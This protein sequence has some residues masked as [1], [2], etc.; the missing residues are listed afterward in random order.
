MRS[1]GAVRARRSPEARAWRKWYKTAA[2]QRLRGAQLAK[3]PLCQCPHCQEGKQRTT[4]ATVVDHKIPH[5]G[6]RRLFFDSKNLRSMSKP[7][8]D[9]FKQ[10]Q[11]RGGAGFFKGVD[12]RGWP[13]S[14]DHEWNYEKH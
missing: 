12:E 11:E 3:H 6:D 14:A 9:A 7:C 5:K 2:W 1:Q 8:H 13:L 10:S 4:T